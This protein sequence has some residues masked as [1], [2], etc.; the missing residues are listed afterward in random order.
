MQQEFDIIIVGGGLVGNAL[1]WALKDLPLNMAIIERDS[2]QSQLQFDYDARSIALSYGSK[3]IFETGGMWPAL[4]AHAA[5]IQ[6]VHVSEQGRFG[7]TRIDATALQVPALGYVIEMH[8]FLNAL[9]QALKT[10]PSLT[11]I[12]P[13]SVVD[14]EKSAKGWQIKTLMGTKEKV[15]NT[16]LLIAADGAASQLRQLQHIEAVETHYGQH[17]VI[18]NI[19]LDADHRH[20][21]YERFTPSGPIAFLPMLEQ[22]ASLVWS[23]N[24]AQVADV[25]ALDQQAFL[26]KLQRHFGYRLGKFIKVGQRFS[27]PLKA[28]FAQE[29]VK[30]GFVLLGNAAHTLHPIAGQGFN[31]CLRDIYI[32][33]ELLKTVV[34][35][36]QP[37]GTLSLMQKYYDL[38]QHDQRL[39]FRYCDSLVR[40]FSNNLFPLTW[41]RNIGLITCDL[42]PFCKMWLATMSMGLK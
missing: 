32:L 6:R 30:P 31:L 17:A 9:L 25:L 20:I 22:R 7:M 18:A 36:Q 1:A 27:Y 4:D 8:Y 34:Q 38:R 40:L 3:Q 33:A 39:T 14:L 21:A 15:Y 35:N 12:S 23:M 16:S 42:I 10:A 2:M 28:C 11:R 5:P 26:T 19:G 41:L 37:L 13:A 24:T 29:Q